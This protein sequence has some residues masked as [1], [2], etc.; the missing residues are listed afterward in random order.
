VFIAAPAAITAAKHRRLHKELYD[1]GLARPFD[2]TYAVWAH[3]PLN[4]A[5]EIAAAAE[6]LIAL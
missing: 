2:G 1:A 3:P 6:K 5:A 4:A